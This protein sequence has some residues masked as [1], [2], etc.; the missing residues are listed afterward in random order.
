M[1][2][3]LS[4]MAN[5]IS[6]M[7]T[8][9]LHHVR[10]VIARVVRWLIREDERAKLHRMMMEY[11]DARGPKYPVVMPGPVQRPGPQANMFGGFQLP[12]LPAELR[13]KVLLE[14]GKKAYPILVTSQDALMS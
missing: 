8:H 7:T 14:E 9:P 1:A 4:K 11:Q 13:R 6:D 2:D 10:V 12:D 5:A 3:T